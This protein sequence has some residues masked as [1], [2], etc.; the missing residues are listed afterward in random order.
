MNDEATTLSVN[1]ALRQ[2]EERLR[3]VLEGIGEAFYVLDSDWR[4]LF[5]SRAALALWGRSEEEV[6][7]RALLDAFPSAKDGEAYWAQAR[8]MA[9]GGPEHLETR[10]PVLDRWIEADISPTAEGGVSVALRDIDARKQ[11]EFALRE[12]E[13]R[14]N[15]LLAELQH[16]VRNTLAV[17]RSIA[18]RT[19][20]NSSSVEEMLA[21]FQGRLDAFSRVQAKLAR[22]P[23]ATVDLMSLIED[24][25]VAHAAREGEQVRIEGPEIALEQK[26]A[27]RLSLAVHELTTNAVK[28]G[29]LGS[30]EGKVS[31]DWQLQ[32]E[33]DRAML[34]FCWEESGVDLGGQ[35]PVREGFGME[36]LKRS[37]PYD[38]DAETHVH[39]RP[40][41]MKFE[42]SM[43]LRGSAGA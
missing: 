13:R 37:L 30:D 33:P 16:R 5:A 4:F 1:D 31:I 11:A 38:L 8:V 40:E 2:S 19:A 23:D 6:I 27:E 36:L 25:L 39:F 22:R 18:R 29:A 42:L 20:E 35:A 14:A 15:T 26:L 28:H 7:G 32:R 34:L 3:L 24:E 43:P 12:S 41:G 21:H 9:G 10:S 17:V